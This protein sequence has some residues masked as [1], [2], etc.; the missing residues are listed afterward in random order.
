MQPPVPHDISTTITTIAIPTTMMN[1]HDTRRAMPVP[2]IAAL[3]GSLSLGTIVFA[4]RTIDMV[5]AGM[6]DLR[7]CSFVG[8]VIKI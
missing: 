8:G 2:M 3:W 6:M 4:E 5:V 7:L 1:G